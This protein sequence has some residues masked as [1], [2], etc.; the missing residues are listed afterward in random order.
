MISWICC[1]VTNDGSMTKRN[2]TEIFKFIS[3]QNLNLFVTFKHNEW[4]HECM[5][6]KSAVRW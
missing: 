1:V 6:I 4:T 2:W 5:N 3:L